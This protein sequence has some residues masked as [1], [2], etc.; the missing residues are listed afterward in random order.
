TAAAWPLAGHAQQSAMPVVGFL[1]ARGRDESAHLVA[2]FRSGLAENGYSEGR[3]VAIEYRW[4]D[5]QYDRLPALAAELVRKP[6]TVIATGGGQPAALA[7]KAATDTIPI[8]GAFSADPVA[9]GLIGSLA[10]PGGNMT[11]VSNLS[12][13]LE[14]KRLGLLREAVR[15]TPT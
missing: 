5:G 1:S 8:V 9:A 10:R 3:N 13:A 14:P 12:T 11:G 7:A 4:A 15:A 2:A 6:V